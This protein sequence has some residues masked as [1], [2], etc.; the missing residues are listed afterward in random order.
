MFDKVIILIKSPSYT[1]LQFGFFEWL[2]NPPKGVLIYP[3]ENLSS[4]TW[5][6]PSSLCFG[7]SHVAKRPNPWIG[8]FLIVKLDDRG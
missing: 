1:A 6:I 3:W 4:F 5:D 7:I 8:D 2:K